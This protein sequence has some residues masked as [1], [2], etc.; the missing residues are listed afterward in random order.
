MKETIPE[1]LDSCPVPD[2]RSSRTARD[3]LP[4]SSGFPAGLPERD[5]PRTTSENSIQSAGLRFDSIFP[6]AR[7]SLVLHAAARSTDHRG[8]LIS[9][10]S[11]V[12]H[13]PNSLPA[14]SNDPTKPGSAP[15]RRETMRPASELRPDFLRATAAES[16]SAD[17]NRPAVVPPGFA[18]YPTPRLPLTTDCSR[19]RAG[20]L[21][22][23]AG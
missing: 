9:D 7:L 16:E 22:L 1:K 11:A 14:R 18:A 6:A 4:P 20:S 10:V 8:P 5:D 23:Q 17:Q 3:K 12:R 2:R 21:V 19:P 13:K 15:A